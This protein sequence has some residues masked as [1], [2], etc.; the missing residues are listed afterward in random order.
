MA[1]KAKVP[2]MLSI[3]P[4]ALFLGGAY[5]AHRKNTSVGKLFLYGLGGFAIGVLPVMYYMNTHKP[6]VVTSSSD[7]Q[8]SFADT[9]EQNEYDK[10]VSTLTKDNKLNLVITYA[11]TYNMLTKK[12]EQAAFKKWANDKLSDDDIAFMCKLAIFIDENQDLDMSDKTVSKKVLNKYNIDFKE[13]KTKAS[14]E[15]ISTSKF[16]FLFGV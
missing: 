4:Y 16:G 6:K 7:T 1:D 9:K 8:H 10:K 11:N 13:S 3:L 2:L 12:E 14:W 5:I 15:K